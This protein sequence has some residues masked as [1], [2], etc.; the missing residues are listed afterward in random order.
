[1]A[2]EPDK[3][4]RSLGLQKKVSELEGFVAEALRRGTSARELK[5]ICRDAVQHSKRK[6]SLDLAAPSLP[7]A[8]LNMS[9]LGPSRLAASDS[10]PC[11]TAGCHPAAHGQQPAVDGNP[12]KL[13]LLLAECF[14]AEHSVQLVQQLATR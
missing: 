3:A 5:E 13:L 6:A 7:E 1:M 14:L 10:C 9:K 11:S 4:E 8:L 12:G 2:E